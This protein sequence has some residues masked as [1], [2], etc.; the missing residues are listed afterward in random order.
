M[1]RL[2]SIEL[3]GD[4][5]VEWPSL[6]LSKRESIGQAEVMYTEAGAQGNTMAL[7]HLGRLR[8]MACKDLD[9]A[10]VAFRA[11]IKADP[12]CADAYLALGELLFEQDDA[13]GAEAA[14]R[15]TIKL[16]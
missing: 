14:F 7:V 12:S 1:S 13:D 16:G 9:G 3:P 10:E 11:A 6:P 8:T 4:E 15:A 5:F 2:N